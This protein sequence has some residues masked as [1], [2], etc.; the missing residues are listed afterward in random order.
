MKSTFVVGKKDKIVLGGKK[1]VILYRGS[2][3]IARLWI[4]E[5]LLKMSFGR[6]Q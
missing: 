2:N 1:K 3:A 5:N 6:Y 4:Q